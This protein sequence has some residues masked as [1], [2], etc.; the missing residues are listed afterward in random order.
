MVSVGALRD[1][2]ALEHAPLDPGV[3]PTE[4]VSKEIALAPYDES[5]DVIQ[6]K[7]V[8]KI[9]HSHVVRAHISDFLLADAPDHLV[10]E[11][12]VLLEL[13]CRDAPALV[14]AQ[15]ARHDGGVDHP[16]KTF[17]WNLLSL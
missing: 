5:L 14:P 9:T 12:P 4:N 17:L 13:I 2:D 16:A 7:P 15:E 11:E 3:V 6:M 10:Q 8:I 1:H